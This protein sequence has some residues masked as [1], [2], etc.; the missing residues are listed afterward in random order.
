MIPID[1][2]TRRQ[3]NF[4]TTL[5]LGNTHDA[6]SDLIAEVIVHLRQEWRRDIARLERRLRM[7][8]SGKALDKAE[9]T[10]LRGQV[11]ASMIDTSKS[12]SSSAVG[13]RL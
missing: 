3:W 8:D 12:R 5:Q 10:E 9:I 4:R 13:G 7:V 6:Q 11:S 2:L 1:T